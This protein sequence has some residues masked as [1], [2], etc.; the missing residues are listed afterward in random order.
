MRAT[1]Q[2]CRILFIYGILFFISSF[3]VLLQYLHDYLLVG[4]IGMK[5]NKSFCSLTTQSKSFHFCLLVWLLPTA[6]FGWVC[7]PIT[8]GRPDLLAS[9]APIKLPHPGPQLTPMSTQLVIVETENV[10]YSFLCLQ[11]QGRRSEATAKTNDIFK[12]LKGLCHKWKK[13][14]RS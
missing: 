12:E 6:T 11:K 4:L 2:N 9:A 3:Y 1:E 14:S 7:W 5:L 10:I 13:Y 8:G